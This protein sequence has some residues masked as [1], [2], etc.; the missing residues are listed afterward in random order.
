MISFVDLI[1]QGPNGSIP[2]WIWCAGIV[3]VG[4]AGLVGMALG[5]GLVRWYDTSGVG[6]FFTDLR[7]R[8]EAVDA[9]KRAN[10]AQTLERRP[11]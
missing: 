8:Q 6:L 9:T 10:A 4:G 3:I 1:H 5:R 7:Q 2:W 11:N